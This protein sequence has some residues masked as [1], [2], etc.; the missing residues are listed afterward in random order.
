MPNQQQPF[1]A[2]SL[3]NQRVDT[4]KQI[5]H[6]SQKYQNYSE[7]LKNLIQWTSSLINT[8]ERHLF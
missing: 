5:K 8:G 7:P 6:I 2:P 3:A 1:G 4:L